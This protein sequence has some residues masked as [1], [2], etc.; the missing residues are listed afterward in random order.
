MKKD[1]TSAAGNAGGFYE[2]A[3][4]LLGE[5]R[6]EEALEALESHLANPSAMVRSATLCDIGAAKEGLGDCE[7]AAEAF[8][9]ALA[10]AGE[11]GP[12][13]LG[14]LKEEARRGLKRLENPQP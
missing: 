8:R 5:G 3:H 9:R 7:G 6:Y 13:S 14:D 12:N 2:D 10:A 11:W 1:T 4:K